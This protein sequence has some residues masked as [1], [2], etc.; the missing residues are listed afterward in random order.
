MFREALDSDMQLSFLILL[1]DNKLYCCSVYIASLE[2][3][4]EDEKGKDP[5]VMYK[6]ESPGSSRSRR[7]LIFFIFFY[8]F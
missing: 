4:E 7:M 1:I 6:W 8:F 2:N 3:N 5:V